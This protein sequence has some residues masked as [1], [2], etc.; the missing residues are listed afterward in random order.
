M[1]KR[2]AVVNNCI[3][4]ANMSRRF[5]F[6]LIKMYNMK[7]SLNSLLKRLNLLE[8]KDLYRTAEKKWRD[9]GLPQRTRESL[10]K[11]APTAFFCINEEPF[12]LFFDAP[13]KEKEKLIQRQI[14]NFNRAISKL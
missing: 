4:G 3:N 2:R 8:N 9:L 11:I 7:M 1:E 13:G 14:W 12:V 10:E 6:G 5:D